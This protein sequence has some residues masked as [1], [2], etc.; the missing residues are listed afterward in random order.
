[1]KG[2][3]ICFKQLIAALVV[4]SL[5]EATKIKSTGYGQHII[6]RA[7]K[8]GYIGR[9]EQPSEV[10][11]NYLVIYYLTPKGKRFVSKLTNALQD[12]N[13]NNNNN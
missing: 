12:N 10:K 1:M 11:G 9:K 3:Y 8:E 4:L 13:N 5:Q 7:L 2:L 6:R